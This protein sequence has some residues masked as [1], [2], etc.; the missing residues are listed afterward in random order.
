MN[1]EYDKETGLVFANT[2]PFTK[3]SILRL[4]KLFSDYDDQYELAVM[5]YDQLNLGKV[6]VDAKLLNIL[7]VYLPNLA[8]EEDF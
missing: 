5:V 4:E 7:I 6:L 1:I 8:S 3:E 2:V